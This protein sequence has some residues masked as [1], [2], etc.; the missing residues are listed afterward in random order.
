MSL[1][2]TKN[3]VLLHKCLHSFQITYQL[4]EASITKP[5][6]RFYKRGP[7]CETVPT[8]GIRNTLQ[9]L[10]PLSAWRPE[11]KPLVDHKRAA[12][13][14]PGQSIQDLIYTSINTC[15]SRVLTGPPEAWPEEVGPG[16]NANRIQ[17]VC[18]VFPT[19]Y[20]LYFSS[21]SS[22]L[23]KISTKRKVTII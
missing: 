9:L 19:S 15:H 10:A 13:M 7:A 2:K 11:G 22:L 18:D 17:K 8:G 5:F 6:L 14:C 1:K 16:C 20:V 4:T 3:A 23:R 12:C 21:L